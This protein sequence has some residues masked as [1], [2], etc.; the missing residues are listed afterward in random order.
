[1]C[2]IVDYP[3]MCTSWLSIIC[4]SAVIDKDMLQERHGPHSEGSFNLTVV[5]NVL[6]MIF[7]IIIYSKVR[8]FKF[9]TFDDSLFIVLRSVYSFG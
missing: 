6:D 3:Y 8:N 4:S 5:A 7:Y 9:Y 2:D 1:M